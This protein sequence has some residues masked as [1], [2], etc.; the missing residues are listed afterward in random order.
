MVRAV[1]GGRCAPPRG[2]GAG[3]AGGWGAREWVR[4]GGSGAP[5]HAEHRSRSPGTVA[6][7]KSEVA[8][9]C[10]RGAGIPVVSADELARQATVEPGASG[11]AEVRRAFGECAWWGPTELWT[12]PRM[13]ALVFRDEAGAS[14]AGGDSAPAYRRA[15]GGVDAASGAAERHPLVVA[16]IPL[17][18]ESRTGVLEFDVTGRRWMR[19]SISRLQPARGEERGLGRGRGRMHHGRAARPGREARRQ[20][21]HVLVTTMAR[22]MQLRARACHWSCW[23]RLRTQAKG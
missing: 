2:I 22:W 1:R 7:G 8:R 21:D 4:A 23:R 16:E 18:F 20:A 13:R 10:G 12:G 9:A 15:P 19:R 14:A 17:L 5:E 6:A 11:L 3:R